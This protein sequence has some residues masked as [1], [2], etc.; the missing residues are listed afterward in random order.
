MAKSSCR[1][2]GPKVILCHY[3]MFT[4]YGR[5]DIIIIIILFFLIGRL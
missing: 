5:D 3:F 4:K 2:L 1:L